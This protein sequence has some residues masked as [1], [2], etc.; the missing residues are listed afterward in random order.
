MAPYVWDTF[1]HIHLQTDI[2]LCWYMKK[3]QCAFLKSS[4]PKMRRKLISEIN[5]ATLNL[6][7]SLVKSNKSFSKYRS[8]RFSSKVSQLSSH[9]FKVL[10]ISLILQKLDSVDWCSAIKSF[11]VF[12]QELHFSSNFFRSIFMLARIAKL[13]F[14]GN[15]D[16]FHIRSPMADFFASSSF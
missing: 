12:L 11:I 3:T 7:S 8:S 1:K 15:C 14:K 5:I 6:V 10:E 4:S 2:R 16:P 13:N 9:V